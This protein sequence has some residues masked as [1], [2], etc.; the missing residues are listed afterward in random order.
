M[1]VLFFSA[2]FQVSE[3]LRFF[4]SHAHYRNFI[5]NV[6]CISSFL[7]VTGKKTEGLHTC[8]KTVFSSYS[9]L[10]S[11]KQKWWKPFFKTFLVLLTEFLI[12]QTKKAEIIYKMIGL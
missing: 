1:V 4:R 9:Y 12:V 3:I 7:A 11:K 10:I 2:L 8:K 5:Y 6:E